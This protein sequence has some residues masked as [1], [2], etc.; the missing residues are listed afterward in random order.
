MSQQ[1]MVNATRDQIEDFINS[2]LWK[3]I[4]RELLK[5]KKDFNLEI[6]QITDDAKEN[7][8]STASV[9]L[10]IGDINGRKKAIDYLLSLPNVLLQVLIDQQTV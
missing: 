4:R 5:W 6:D 9:L 8:P 3:D 10:H 2:V 7:N 1:L